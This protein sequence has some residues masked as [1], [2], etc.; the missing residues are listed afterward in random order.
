MLTQAIMSLP[1]DT[2]IP[3]AE[4]ACVRECFAWHNAGEHLF[5]QR[6]AQAQNHAPE[7]VKIVISIV[8]IVYRMPD[9]GAITKRDQF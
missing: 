1:A 3:A 8:L 9:I 4:D 6:G 5:P 2:H 7:P